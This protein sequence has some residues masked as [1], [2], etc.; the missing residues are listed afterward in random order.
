MEHPEGRFGKHRTQDC[1]LDVSSPFS[2]PQ[3]YRW[4][5]AAP[6]DGLS[7]MWKEKRECEIC[8]V[9][10]EEKKGKEKRGQKI[11]GDI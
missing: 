9:H 2:V 1:S 4:S 11:S 8:V 3:Q 5:W 6:E 10:E 7:S